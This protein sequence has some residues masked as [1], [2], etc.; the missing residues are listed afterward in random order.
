MLIEREELQAIIDELAA[1]GFKAQ[2][3]GEV[4]QAIAEAAE[5]SFAFSDAYWAISAPLTAEEAA[6]AGE[7]LRAAALSTPADIASQLWDT[8][9]S[10]R[11]EGALA[12]SRPT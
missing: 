1:G 10:W 6:A 4:L 3:S 12:R 5:G 7:L 9:V 11:V 8:I 2:V